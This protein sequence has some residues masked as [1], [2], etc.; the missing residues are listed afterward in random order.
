MSSELRTSSPIDR[1]VILISGGSMGF[2]YALAKH[3]LLEGFSIAFF[4]RQPKRVNLSLGELE[5]IGPVLGAVGDVSNPVFLASFVTNILNRFG[6]LDG[7]VQNASTLGDLPLPSLLDLSPANLRT[8]F[9]TNVVAPLVL[10]QQSLPHLLRQPRSVIVGMSSDAAVA[11]YPGWGAY[12][13]SK[14]AL[15]L[16]Q[17]TLAH[18]THDT[19][20]FSYALDPGDMATALHEAALP[21]DVGL[22]DPE[23][24]AQATLALFRPLIHRSEPRLP[25]G[26]WQVS[27]QTLVRKGEW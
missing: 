3:L 7:V 14:A 6:R 19:K 18:E 25:E 22:A 23:T 10:L 13:A 17:Q 12:G 8:V 27:D 16:L 11:G 4:A 15:D 9:E 20:L 26:R 5:S 2:G 21:G 1:P 24:V